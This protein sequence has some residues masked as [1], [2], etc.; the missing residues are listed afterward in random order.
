MSN[1]RPRLCCPSAVGAL[2]DRN[3]WCQSPDGAV[4]WGSLADGL[5]IAKRE[6]MSP[7]R[8]RALT[9]L[10]SP[11]SLLTLFLVSCVCLC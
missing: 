7:W 2:W 1:E 10:R 11:D 3:S 6:G 9:V 4:R 5:V 8:T